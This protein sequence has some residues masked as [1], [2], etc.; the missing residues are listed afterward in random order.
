M[1]P[2]KVGDTVRIHYTGRLEDGTEFDSSRGREPLE[3]TLGQHQVIA[4]LEDAVEGMSPGETKTARVP[5]ERA[6]GPH[7][8]DRLLAVER[9]RFPPHIQPQAGQALHMTRNGQPPAPVTVLVV[10]GEVVLVDTNH[11]LAGRDLTFELELLGIAGR[12]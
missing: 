8:E 2:A 5:A 11:P 12:P 7:R 9:H 4:G 10:S 3:F 1:E 6:H